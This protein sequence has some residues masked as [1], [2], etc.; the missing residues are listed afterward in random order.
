MQAG[1]HS[2]RAVL[3]VLTDSSFFDITDN[4]FRVIII[5]GRVPLYTYTY[6]TG[7]RYLFNLFR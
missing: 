3:R 6:S 1:I 5:I 7:H 4:N 2:K